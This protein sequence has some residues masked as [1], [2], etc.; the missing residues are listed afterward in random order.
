VQLIEA[1]GTDA[2]KFCGAYKIGS[3]KQL[4]ASAFDKA[5]A[6]LLRKLEKVDA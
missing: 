3:V 5:R 2:A 4:P 6:Q 1:T